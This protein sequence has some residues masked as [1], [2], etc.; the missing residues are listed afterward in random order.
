LFVEK[1]WR[2]KINKLGFRV[3]DFFLPEQELINRLVARDTKNE[4]KLNGNFTDA[5]Q[6][7][8]S[9]KKQV[10]SVDSTLA[11]HVEALKT[12]S[13][14]RLHELEKKMLRAEK[15]KFTD[16][17][18]QIHTIKENLFPKNSLQ[19]RTDNFMQ[20]YAKWGA[21]FIGQVYQHSLSLEQEFVILSES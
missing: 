1:K 12:Q 5:E 14:Y 18:R 4:I 19:E 11:G 2:E 13:L 16:Q 7:Y 10:V 6:L 9:L 8:E 3:E 20:Y 17:Q 15:R 21:D